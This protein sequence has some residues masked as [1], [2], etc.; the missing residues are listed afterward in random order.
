MYFCRVDLLKIRCKII[1]IVYLIG[2]FYLV[3]GIGKWYFFYKK[4]F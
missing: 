3:F 2:V 4:I 1:F